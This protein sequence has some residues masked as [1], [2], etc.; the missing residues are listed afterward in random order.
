MDSSKTVVDVEGEAG[1]VD[2]K[3]GGLAKSRMEGE[4]LPSEEEA[5]MVVDLEMA[6]SRSREEGEVDGSGEGRRDFSS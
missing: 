6:V 2:A 4:E 1:K 3:E 5:E